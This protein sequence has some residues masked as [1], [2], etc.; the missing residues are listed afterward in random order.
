M[1]KSRVIKPATK[2]IQSSIYINF[3]FIIYIEIKRQETIKRIEAGIDFKNGSPTLTCIKIA[4][5]IKIAIM[6]IEGFS[7]NSYQ[8][9]P[10]K[11]MAEPTFKNPTRVTDQFG[12]P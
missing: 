10:I 6:Y 2:R 5:I 11:A 1:A 7:K 12:K 9:D 8:I 4:P 3:L